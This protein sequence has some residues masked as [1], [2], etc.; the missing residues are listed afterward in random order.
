MHKDE[1]C[2]IRKDDK[3]SKKIYLSPS[4]QNDNHYAVGNTTEQE[5]CRRI[6]SACEKALLRCG[7]QVI[8]AAYGTMYT[9]VA[10]S[11][12]WGAD[13]HVPI[14][15]NAANRKIA[16]TRMFCSGLNNESYKATKAIYDVLAPYT[17]GTSEGIKVDKSLYEIKSTKCPCAY[18]EVEF[19]DNPT[20]AQWI[21]DNVED[22]G[23]VIAQGICNYFNVP[24]SKHSSDN[25]I[26][27]GEKKTLDTNTLDFFVS[28]VRRVLKVPGTDMKI[29]LDRTITVSKKIN[30]RHEIVRS[31]QTYLT[32]LGYSEIGE[33][34][35]IAGDKFEAA[36]KRY[37]KEHSCVQDG[38]I[39][40]RNKTWRKLLN[41][42]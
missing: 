11:N 14:H 18:T 6:S 13:L 28:D 31:I 34:D 29:L 23:E 19:H 21:I 10:E 25:K 26:S 39:T 12:K 40:A 36:V 41:M 35:G 32:K 30:R 3:M 22:I 15:T 9:R 17:P 38:E 20:I 27:A 8:N 4:S 1:Q 37:Q 2:S 33:I 5:Q 24:Y 16:G 42:E 7:F